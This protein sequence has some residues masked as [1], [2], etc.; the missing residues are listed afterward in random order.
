MKR[1]N[2]STSKDEQV[3]NKRKRKRLIPKMINEKIVTIALAGTLV[4]GVAGLAGCNNDISKVDPPNQVDPDTGYSQLVTDLAE[5]DYYNS[6]IRKAANDPDVL[7]GPSFDPHPYGFLEDQG[8]DT[9]GIKKGNLEC[10]TISFTR[11]EEPNNLY[12]MTYAEQDSSKPYFNEY[13]IRYTLSDSEMEDYKYLHENHYIQAQFI[14]DFI[15]QEKDPE[16]L[17]YTKMSVNAHKNLA[18]SLGDGSL[19]PFVKDIV[20]T[21][22]IDFV[23]KEYSQET[24]L[25]TVYLFPKLELTSSM[26][27]ND[28]FAELRL[29]QHLTP[30]TIENDIFMDPSTSAGFLPN[31]LSD[32]YPTYEDW[33]NATQTVEYY[34]NQTTRLNL[35]LPNVT[36]EINEIN[37]N[38]DVK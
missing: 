38:I 20:R 31:V 33:K 7:N 28:K 18:D 11:K 13:M 2:S 23:L 36:D 19:D 16:I 26:N 5:N 9:D 30:I 35:K 32:E 22:N 10:K 14:N 27:T 34:S 8:I 37:A 1:K 15:S 25:F 21:N 17:S 4:L 6:L 29:T 12:I 3:F 24:G